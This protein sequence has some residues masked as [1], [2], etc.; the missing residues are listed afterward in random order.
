MFTK[1]KQTF[2]WQMCIAVGLLLMQSLHADAQTT[3]IGAGA[4]AGITGSNAGPIYRSS[5]GS[6]FDYSQHVYLYTAAELSAAGI[7]PGSVITSI[8]W[9]KSNA[10]GTAATN[11]SSIWNVTMKNSS[12][13]Q[14]SGWSN[15]SYA[16]QMAGGTL[17]Y[18]NS[19]QVI[20]V[21]AGY[22]TLTLAAP[23]LYTGGSLEIGSDWNCSVFAGSP[24]TGG[25]AWRSDNIANACFGGSNSAASMTMS[26]QTIRPQ[27]E[28]GYNAPVACSGTPDP[29]TATGPASVCS[30]SL[31]TLSLSPSQAVSGL[32]YQWESAD[33][34]AF[35]VNVT[36][37]GTS[38]SQVISQT[39]AKYYRCNVTCSNSGLSTMSSAHYVAM[40]PFYSCYCIPT[41]TN[42][43]GAGDHI[44]NVTVNT[45][46]NP[47]NNTTGA[48]LSASYSSYQ[49]IVADAYQGDVI[50]VSVSVNNGGTE[51]A[52]GWIDLNQNG[53]FDAAEFIALTDADA[54]AP[55]IYTG[56]LTIPGGATVGTTGL[57]FRSSYNAPIDANTSCGNYS[58]GETE[59]YLITISTPPPCTGAPAATT[60]S[61]ATATVCPGTGATLTVSSPGIFSGF[62]YQWEESVDDLTYN[63]I[64]G[65]NNP[66][67]TA[68]PT[69][70]MYYR[71]VVTCTNSSLFT[72]STTA[73]I[74]Y[75]A[76]A[77]AGSITGPSTS[78][79]YQTL[80]YVAGTT[81]GDLQWQFATALA[82]PYTDLTGETSAT[83]NTNATSAGIFYIRLRATSPS[84]TTYS[85]II[86]TTV[87]VDGDNVCDAIPLA[88]GLNG[89]YTNQGATIE[90]GEAQAPNTACNSQSAW[91]TGASGL[92]NNTVWFTLVAPP[93]G[94]VSI[95]L[96][97]TNLWDSQIALWSASS[98]SD[99]TS[100][101]GTLIA[102]N[103]D[104]A[105]SPFNSKIVSACVTPGQTY[106]VQVD[107]YGT[108]IKNNFGLLI[109]EELN[110]VPEFDACPTTVYVN[111]ECDATTAEATWSEPS[112][113]DECLA[114]GTS[115]HASGSSFPIGTTTVTYTANDGI[116]PAVTC[117]FDVVVTA[118]TSTSTTASATACDN[119]TWAID[120]MNY[121]ASGTYTATSTNEQ[122]CPHTD[123]LNLTINPLPTVSAPDVSMCPGSSVTLGG[124]PS[125]GVWNLPNPYSGTAISYM[126]TYTDMNGCTNSA[127]GAINSSS[128]VMSNVQAT[129]VTGISATITYAPINGIGWYEIRYR[130]TSSATWIVGTNNNSTS[131]L[132]I[133][134]T[135]NSAYEVQVRG[136][137]STT[138]PGAWSA[139]V[140]FN[141]N[142][143]C[144]TPS[145]LFVNNISGTTA[146][147]NWGAISGAGYYTVRWKAVSSATWITT[148]SNTNSKAIAGLTPNT[149]YEFQ[150]RTNCGN[151]ASPYSASELFTTAGSKGTTAVVTETGN[152]ISLYPNPT[153]DV[154]NIDLSVEEFTS[155]TIKVMDMSGRVVKT[156]QANAEIGINK[157][158]ISLGDLSNGVYSVQTIGNDKLINVT[159]VIKN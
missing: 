7:L 129:N 12:A 67:Y 116:N 115:S 72:N 79:T 90:T 47:I 87:T 5:A 86:T 81:V 45:T 91:C 134:L 13:T 126:Y 128:A 121:T 75:D 21:A 39:G 4:S 71:C 106:Y 158:S 28:L 53:T 89:P 143:I 2:L 127:S 41:T 103:D 138:N 98:C 96:D 97:P 144:G 102:A 157:I 142:N 74:T 25:F 146:K 70:N 132:L 107:G 57:R 16:T 22:I 62:T 99:L 151:S 136:Y 112:L 93:S 69:S 159:R 153:N 131:K 145:G 26:S 78:E 73:Y 155:T 31:F 15:T 76:S 56:T 18:S 43:C 38:M 60:V 105:G 37:L 114:T 20:P 27:V 17:V 152:G 6:T 52:A 46:V 122:G 35:T 9:N 48:C 133:N 58:Y 32:T 29:T 42:G 154:I 34:A 8:A 63:P 33:D 113:L 65:A 139:S 101:L 95:E 148:T 36:T 156:V 3:I 19:A 117:S 150:V 30:G 82:G 24:T 1:I 135:P 108:T 120:G 149:N 49:S 40:N 94:I 59:D 104:I 88:V 55:W 64:S 80:S 110:N 137:C 61:P 123:V 66:T 100:G 68:S 111:T 130:L 119:Y 109:T 140:L 77:D 125:G 83:L 14:V 11:L 44:T 147:L 124:S 85:N 50:S 118:L 92:I 84:C 141:T 54:V 10:F 51:Y 23:F